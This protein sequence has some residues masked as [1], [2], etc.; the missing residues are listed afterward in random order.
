MPLFA[1]MVLALFNRVFS[2][3]VAWLKFKF[4]LRIAVIV[5]LATM[6]TAGLVAFQNFVSPFLAA[7]FSTAYGQLIGLAFPPI[8]GTVVTGLVTLWVGSLLYNYYERMGM[9]LIK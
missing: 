3:V 7:L 1:A 8:A 4:G 5:S 6:Y 2:F 9:A